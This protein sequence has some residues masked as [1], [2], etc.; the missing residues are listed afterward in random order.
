[1][2]TQSKAHIGNLSK[3]KGV[4]AEIILRSFMLE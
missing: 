1:M 3:E 4:Q 2:S